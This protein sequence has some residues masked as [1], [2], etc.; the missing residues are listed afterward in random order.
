MGYDNSNVACSCATDITK[1]FCCCQCVYENNCECVCVRDSVIMF[2]VMYHWV[3][4]RLT[5]IHNEAHAEEK[6]IFLF[7]HFRF[8]FNAQFHVECTIDRMWVRVDWPG[9]PSYFGACFLR[10]KCS[11]CNLRN[12]D[13]LTLVR[14][15]I[16]FLRTRLLAHL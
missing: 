7:L 16:I 1:R 4:I 3:S 9:V 12:M 11:S 5:H 14:W 15:S 10:K 8:Q 6:Y 2:H 13:I